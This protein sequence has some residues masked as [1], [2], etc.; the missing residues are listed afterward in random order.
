MYQKASSG[1]ADI[2]QQALREILQTPSLVDSFLSFR[3]ENLTP[4]CVA[5]INGHEAVCRAMVQLF[6]QEIQSES[7]LKGEN[8]ILNSALRISFGCENRKMFKMVFKIAKEEVGPQFL[9][10]VKLQYICAGISTGKIEKLKV[11]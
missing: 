5:A 8:G 10:F 2:F 4:F 9:N 6:I 3:I 1:K 7:Y 11:F